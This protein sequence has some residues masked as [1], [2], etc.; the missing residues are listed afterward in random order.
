M[1]PIAHQPSCPLGDAW[2]PD[3]GKLEGCYCPGAP[4]PKHDEPKS[5]AH[6]KGRGGRCPSL[7]DY[8]RGRNYVVD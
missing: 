3:F 6:L 4:R 1:K 2:H 5:D 7:S 8:D